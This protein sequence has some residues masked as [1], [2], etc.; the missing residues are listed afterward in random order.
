MERASAPATTSRDSTSPSIT[1]SL[2]PRSLLVGYCAWHS[3][4][5]ASD[6]QSLS[7][8]A[9]MA[10]RSATAGEVGGAGSRT[11][12]INCQDCRN[13]AKEDCPHMRC[14]TCC[15]SRG[16]ECKTHMKSTWVPAAK[17]RK[18]QQQLMA[19]QDH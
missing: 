7:R 3:V 11:T 14:R 4:S 13:Q 12:G 19:L 5:R 2:P 1:S 9:V 6:E 15:K 18:R 16:Y 17:R 10:M 8:S